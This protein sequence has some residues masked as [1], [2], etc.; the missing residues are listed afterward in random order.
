[1]S[2]IIINPS[3]RFDQK[4]TTT[5]REDREETDTHLSSDLLPLSSLPQRSPDCCAG[6]T[7]T[8]TGAHP[9]CATFLLPQ[10]VTA[11]ARGSMNSEVDVLCICIWAQRGSALPLHPGCGAGCCYVWPAADRPSLQPLRGGLESQADVRS[12]VAGACTVPLRARWEAA[13]ECKVMP[14]EGAPLLSQMRA[15]GASS[16]TCLR[17][18]RKG[19]GVVEDCETA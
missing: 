17:R 1:M 8:A 16:R 4:Q 5:T 12:R 10:A 18:Q 9:P 14:P 2:S 15:A 3:F 13:V 6:C 19:A 11:A 7:Y